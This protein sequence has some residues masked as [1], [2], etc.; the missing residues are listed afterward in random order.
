MTL[1]DDAIGPHAPDDVVTL[2]P[3]T[4]SLLSRYPATPSRITGAK[5]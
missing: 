5:A 1:P 3:T 4:T 2:T